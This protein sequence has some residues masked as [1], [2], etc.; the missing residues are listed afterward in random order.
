MRISCLACGQRNPTHA[1][2][3]WECGVEL[4]PADAVPR[5][6]SGFGWASLLVVVLVVTAAAFIHSVD[7][8]AAV[9]RSDVERMIERDFDLDREKCGPLF[10]L[11][12][13]EE[14]GSLWVGR[15]SEG[16][17]VE[18]TPAAIG[19]LERFVELVTRLDH[20][21]PR[22]VKSNMSRF[23]RTWETSRTYELPQRVRDALFQVLAFDDVPVLVDRRGSSRLE[24]DASPFDQRIVSDM[25]EVL[26][27]S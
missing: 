1:L 11:L 21:N 25:I 27:G 12:A 4:C 14:V 19:A 23:R 8:R 7:D 22:D 26:G 5:R 16:V 24:V 13:L 18:G 9:A 3:C 20:L 2:F 10:D 15:L 6:K 17:R